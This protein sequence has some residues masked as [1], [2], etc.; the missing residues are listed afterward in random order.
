MATVSFPA[1]AAPRLE[2]KPRTVIASGATPNGDVVFFAVLNRPTGIYS[3]LA[4]V[5][6][7]VK[8]DAQGTAVL[9]VD[10]DVP[11]RSLWFAVDVLRGEFVAA[12]PAGFSVRAASRPL[13]ALR[14]GEASQGDS[15]QFSG[16]TA[17]MLVVRRGGGVWALRASKG[18]S[19]DV[20]HDPHLLVVGLQQ[21]QS[22]TDRTPGPDRL[23]AGDLVI[24]VDTDTLRYSAETVN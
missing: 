24:A 4:R 2:V 11:R 1:A 7:I 3:T 14:R 6:E 5:T 18:G 10:L 23:K 20:G 15:L 21:F 16:G 8:A 12:A 9:N 22:L 19:R 17:D 13:H